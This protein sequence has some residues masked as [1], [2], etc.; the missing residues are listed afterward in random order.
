MVE[1]LGIFFFLWGK[2][3][4]TLK[5]VAKAVSSTDFSKHLPPISELQQFPEYT[6]YPMFLQTLDISSA[7]ALGSLRSSSSNVTI[8]V[9]SVSTADTRF[10]LHKTL[11]GL[12]HCQ[13]YRD[14]Q[15]RRHRAASHAVETIRGPRD[16]YY[17][18]RRGDGIV[19][20]N[21]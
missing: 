11:F 1:V 14:D 3:S 4:A 19:H 13:M 16:G 12:D 15:A 18:R 7:S 21:V 20:V 17:H 6:L 5:D 8:E 10:E 2:T 9:S